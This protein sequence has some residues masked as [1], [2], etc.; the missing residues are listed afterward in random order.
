MKTFIISL[1]SIISL[2]AFADNLVAG[3]KLFTCTSSK[4]SFDIINNSGKNSFLYDGQL[5][6][7]LTDVENPTAM[8]F[9]YYL[10]GMTRNITITSDANKNFSATTSDID[11][12][13]KLISE[14]KYTCKSVL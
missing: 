9:K 13:G 11:I 12:S 10:D 4:D 1:L 2:G 7:N 6:L 5:L 8:Q 14:F 3:T